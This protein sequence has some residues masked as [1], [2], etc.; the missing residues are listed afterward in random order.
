[1]KHKFTPGHHRRTH[2]KSRH[3]CFPCK[4]RKVKCTEEHP[5]CMNCFQRNTPCEYPNPASLLLKRPPLAPPRAGSSPVRIL[6]FPFRTPS[7]STAATDSAGSPAAAAATS[8]ELNLLDL[9]LFHHFLTATYPHLPAGNETIWTTTIPVIAASRPYLM[10]ALLGLAA[11]H[12]HLLSS[13]PLASSTPSPSL[14]PFPAPP[15]LGTNTS[16]PCTNPCHST[17][18]HTSPPP[19]AKLSAT[20]VAHRTAALAGLHASLGLSSSS[21]SRDDVDAMLAA[22]YALTFQATYMLEDGLVDFVTMVRGCALITRQIESASQGN[23]GAGAGVGESSCFTLEPRAFVTV[24]EPGLGRMPGVDAWVVEWG[25][26][27]LEDVRRRWRRRTRREC[28]WEDGEEEQRFFAA[29]KVV[30]TALRDGKGVRDGYV[31]FCEAHAIWY[32]CD[33]AAF[34]RLVDETNTVAQVLMAFFLAL[35]CLL[36]PVF[37]GRCE[38]KRR[39]QVIGLRVLCVGRWV[40]RIREGCGQGWTGELAWVEA[41]VGEVERRARVWLEGG[42][43]EEVSGMWLGV[44]GEGG[45]EGLKRLAREGAMEEGWTREGDQWI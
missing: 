21:W 15:S 4:R 32:D 1:M 43:D 19:N 7:D 23:A 38:F 12:L 37:A 2:T 44:L 8:S 20:G 26:R 11:T 25:L 30:L 14:A 9:R 33:A 17:A 5:Q 36:A 42:W 18:I 6:P 34:E 45:C 3:G 35:E 24:L 29:V 27:A 22:A 40:E 13:S 31:L 10:H 41:V 16:T 28:E 39:Q